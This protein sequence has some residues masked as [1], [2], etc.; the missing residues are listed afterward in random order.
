M[1]HSQV[2]HVE[3]GERRVVCGDAEAAKQKAKSLVGFV[4]SCSVYQGFDSES[5]SGPLVKN[6]LN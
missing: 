5:C 4:L 3:V 2:E 6:I 1:V